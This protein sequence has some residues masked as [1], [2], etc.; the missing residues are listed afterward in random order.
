MFHLNIVGWCRSEYGISCAV[1]L[2]SRT[3]RRAVTS[4]DGDQVGF[5]LVRIESSSKRQSSGHVDHAALSSSQCSSRPG[6]LLG[7]SYTPQA[8][9][10]VCWR[11]ESP[12]R[13]SYV[14][15]K[16]P[17]MRASEAGCISGATPCVLGRLSESSLR[18]G[19]QHSESRSAEARRVFTGRFSSRR[20][21]LGGEASAGPSVRVNDNVAAAVNGDMKTGDYE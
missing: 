15:I 10:P 4:R 6:S 7:V 3:D 14:A 2:A 18:Y 9:R 1:T 17:P 13:I 20:R 12:T 5:R 8:Q 11:V 21:A 19:R 16:T